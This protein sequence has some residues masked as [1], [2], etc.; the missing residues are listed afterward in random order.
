[1][2]Q[3]EMLRPMEAR[4]FRRSSLGKTLAVKLPLDEAAKQR[5]M[6]MRKEVAGARCELQKLLAQIDA[7]TDVERQL[8]RERKTADEWLFGEKHEGETSDE[9]VPI[10]PR[11]TDEFFTQEKRLQAKRELAELAHK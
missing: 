3:I 2:I 10:R 6:D 9:L 4:S 7:E 1:M 8:I 5:A 11:V